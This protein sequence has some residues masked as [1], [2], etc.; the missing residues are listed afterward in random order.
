MTI[1]KNT[2]LEPTTVS[3]DASKTHEFRQ[4]WQILF[5]SFIGVTVGLTALPFYTYGIFLG[6]LQAEFGWSRGQVQLALLF[7]TIGALGMAPVIGWACDKYGVRPVALISMAAYTLALILLS[8]LT[9]NI[10]QYYG[11]LVLLGVFGAGT[12][13]ITWTRAITG[14]FVKNRGIA[15]GIA[16]MGTGL[17]GFFAP[18]IVTSIIEGHGWR[19]AYLAMALAPGLIGLPIVYLFFRERKITSVTINRVLSGVQFSQALADYRFWII[20]IGFFLLSFGI[21]GSIPNLFPIFVDVGYSPAQAAKFLGMIGLSVI[22]GRIVTGLLIDRIW[23]PAVSAVVMALPAISCYL[24]ATGQLSLNNAYACT[25]LFGLAAGAEFD[26]IAYL[27]ARYFGLKNYSKIYSLLY[28]AF[29]L[30]AA[31]APGIF[32][33]MFDMNGNY[34][35]IFMIS[36]GLFIGASLLLLTLGSYPVFSE[37][38]SENDDERKNVT[39]I[40]S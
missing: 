3:G 28:A 36:G 18:P 26:L 37:Q 11:S 1:T 14:Q 16:L 34:N 15:L 21:G 7:Q 2:P 33:Y 10:F 29:A 23:A 19:Q 6:P 25:I 35:V 5:A 17:T 40:P 9:K 30:G 22:V 32:G 27:A 4:G 24:L 38:I 8:L 12:V 13:P 39:D 31:A 20:A